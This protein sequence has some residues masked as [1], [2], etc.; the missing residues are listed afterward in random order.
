[1]QDDSWEVEEDAKCRR[2]GSTRQSTQK[3]LISTQLVS[4]GFPSGRYGL[5]A[6]DVREDMAQ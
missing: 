5:A 3:Y 6:E 2:K 4:P 1:M